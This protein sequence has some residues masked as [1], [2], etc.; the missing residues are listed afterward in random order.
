MRFNNDNITKA[1][2]M[3]D[4]IDAH[5]KEYINGLKIIPLVSG[6]IW[7]SLLIIR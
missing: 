1:H 3:N 5:V 7:K 4:L 2:V 6:Y